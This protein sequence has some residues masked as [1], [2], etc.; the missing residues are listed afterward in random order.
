M[1]TFLCLTV[2]LA[3]LACDRGP[4][5]AHLLWSEDVDALENPFPDQRF[6]LTDGTA[7]LRPDWYKPFIS[8]LNAG[9][10]KYFDG[11]NAQA[12]QE[13]TGFGNFGPILLRTSEP[14]DPA[15][16]A[17][18][19]VRLKKAA[20]GYELLEADVATEHST[21]TLKDTGVTASANFPEF[22][23]SRP[24]I[25]LAQGEEGLLVVKAGIKTQAGKLLGRGFAF[26]DSKS[27]PDLDAVAK[28]LGI[29]KED[30]LL[31]LP[32]K[33]QQVTSD[34]DEVSDWVDAQPAAAVTV[35][36]KAMAAD[37]SVT[38][39]VGLWKSTDADWSQIMYWL[40][41]SAYA[42]NASHVGAVEVGTLA[43]HDLRDEA[44]SKSW[45]KEWVADPSQ[46][47]TVQMAYVLAV[48][49]G[50]K[51]SGGWP[52]VIVAHGL[53]GRNVPVAGTKESYC[54][55]NAELLAAKGIA[56]IGIDAPAHGLRGNFLTDFFVIDDVAAI[57]DQFREM[58]FDLLQ[59]S[60]AAQAL[61]YDQDGQGDFAQDLGY[62]GN[63]LGGIMGSGFVP[64]SK[65]VKYSVLNVPGGGLSNILVS[66]DIRDR[67][68][69]LIC[70]ETG[71][72]FGSEEYYSAFPAF[73]ALMQPFM[74]KGDPINLGFEVSSDRAFLVQ[75]GIGDTTIPNFTTD[76]LAA[77]MGLS[78]PSAEVSGSAP[79]HAIY[80][81]DPAKWLS[82]QQLDGFNGHNVFGAIEDVR[83]QAAEFLAS[84]G[85]HELV[86]K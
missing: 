55:E 62:F 33:A 13:I 51:P 76:N 3:A 74:E 57:R 28:A 42:G 26:D 44:G 16:I 30:V 78:N 72:G 4:E 29:K 12:Q 8:G 84:K 22:I 45:K 50:P 39:P 18:S 71:V 34:L 63:S 14:V 2:A 81:V 36:A 65:R 56:C 41:I 21:D 64:L 24:S 58:T 54:L 7:H 46:S 1:R 11:F 53:G 48:P 38:R 86:P 20:N 60:K 32:F 59:L 40:Q 9:L 82:A 15:S 37:G 75:E 83:T 66:H 77:S 19:M 52:L 79:I 68:G 69:L 73:R 31:A 67:I 61:D 27:K 47:P 43:L 6:I 17:G 5:P 85:T 35:P 10:K 49:A 23:V 80:R 70:A 25:P